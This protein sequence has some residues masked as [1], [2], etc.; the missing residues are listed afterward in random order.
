MTGYMLHAVEGRY[1]MA[2]G[3]E[4]ALPAEAEDAEDA[5]DAP[6][7]A[8]PPPPSAETLAAAPPEVAAY[9]AALQARLAAA[10]AA[11]S[12]AGERARADAARRA[13][14]T[15][16]ASGGNALLAFH[17]ALEASQA[18]A[19][20]GASPELVAATAALVDSLLGRLPP[21]R[22]AGAPTSRG[23]ADALSALPGVEVGGAEGG[24]RERRAPEFSAAL[25]VT[26][27]YA[28]ALLLWAL[29]AGHY[30][31]AQEQR[32]RLEARVLGADA[33]AP[34]DDRWRPFLDGAA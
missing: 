18:A 23:G 10:E 13:A 33:A 3:L 30:A 31:R 8:P 19:L 20:A 25:S 24:S 7:E 17:R 2:R 6:V 28:A 9:A 15:P 34:D 16:P 5:A 22:G 29:G 32:R 26:R 1:R 12:A 14:R 27:E 11:L 21:L 4:A